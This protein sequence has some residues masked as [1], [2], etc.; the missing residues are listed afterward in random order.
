VRGKPHLKVFETVMIVGGI[1]IP[2][3]ISVG[4]AG[5]GILMHLQK[6]LGRTFEKILEELPGDYR[7]HA[8]G[9]ELTVVNG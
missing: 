9:L 2:Q 4:I 3:P 5:C 1:P 7:G 6:T 8:G